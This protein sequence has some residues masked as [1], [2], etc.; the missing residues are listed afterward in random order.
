MTTTAGTG[1]EVDAGAVLS[2]EE[3]DEKLRLG[4]PR[5]FPSL[6]VVDP[7]LMLT[8]PSHLTAFQGFDALFHC[9]ECYINNAN[10]PMG[11]IICREGIRAS[12]LRA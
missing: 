8:V 7:E 6:S 3:T 1:S 2:C 10:T 4:N 5:L 11:D 12:R 9:V